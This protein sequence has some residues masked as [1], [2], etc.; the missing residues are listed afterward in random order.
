[1]IDIESAIRRCQE[2]VEDDSQIII[3]VIMCSSKGTLEKWENTQSTLNNYLRFGEVQKFNDGSN[4]V[5][6]AKQS[7]PKINFRYYIEP[8]ATIP[9]G[10]DLINPD[11]ST[12]TW[13]MQVQGR[14]DGAAARNKPEG[15]YFD[16]MVEWDESH[17]LQKRFRTVRDYISYIIQ[18][19]KKEIQAGWKEEKPHSKEEELVFL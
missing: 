17:E 10:L 16:K 8:T 4:D 9:G 1:M 11:N 6:A 19:E 3:D 13:P 7:H 14:L 15:Y 2:V 18:E 12:V 5:I